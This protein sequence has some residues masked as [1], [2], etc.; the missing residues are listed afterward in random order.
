MQTGRI[1]GPQGDRMVRPLP[2]VFLL[3]HFTRLDCF[4]GCALQHGPSHVRLTFSGCSWEKVDHLTLSSSF[5]VYCGG[6][7][8]C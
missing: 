5:L 4:W 2:S 3:P 8:G 1:P 6:E 7:E